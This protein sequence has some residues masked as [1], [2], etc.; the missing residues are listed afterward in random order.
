MINL[1]KKEMLTERFRVSDVLKYYD[2]IKSKKLIMFL[3][4]LFDIIASFLGLLIC[5]IPFTIIAIIIKTTSKGPAFFLQTRI[6]RYGEPFKIFKFRTMRQNAESEGLRITVGGD[7]RIT[8]IGEFLR[9][10]KIDELPQLINV[11]KGD[12][13]FVGPRPE[14]KEYV[15]IYTDEMMAT[16]LIRPGIT[17][18]ASIKYKSENEVLE[19][20]DDPEYAYI[21]VVLPDKMKY[22][23]EYLNNIS[24]IYDL[25]LIYKTVF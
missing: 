19:Q 12:M 11:L 10:T 23:L 3:K 14:V 2:I 6:G 21:N 5:I 24:P 18:T 17:S 9:K 22:N 8:K 1:I 16:L 25:K 4:R 15:D 7:N 13:S 20:S